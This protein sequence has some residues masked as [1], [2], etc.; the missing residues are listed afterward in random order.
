MIPSPYTDTELLDWLGAWTSTHEGRQHQIYYGGPWRFVDQNTPVR[1]Y[2]KFE[3]MP[4]LGKYET[5][6]ELI[7]AAILKKVNV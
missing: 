7:T 3:D 2:W 5:I 4:E 6:R 1:G